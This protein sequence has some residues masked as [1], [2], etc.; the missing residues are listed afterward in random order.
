MPQ[1]FKASGYARKYSKPVLTPWSDQVVIDSDPA[2]RSGTFP[3]DASY[4]T[5]VTFVVTT[6]M[7]RNR[8]YHVSR[9]IVTCDATSSA[10]LRGSIQMQIDGV[11][12]GSA[13]IMTD[14]GDGWGSHVWNIPVQ[15]YDHGFTITIQVGASNNSNGYTFRHAQID[16][17]VETRI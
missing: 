16:G 7:L 11:T 6:E 4:I 8:S 14:V 1:T 17:I 2:Y 5:Q 10:S 9:L 13:K 3:N 15:D 12:W